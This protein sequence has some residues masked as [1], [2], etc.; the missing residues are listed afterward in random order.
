MPFET[1]CGRTRT[2]PQI[3]WALDGELNLSYQNKEYGSIT[4]ATYIKLF[5]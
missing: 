2:K 4:T 1:T 3:N 5:D